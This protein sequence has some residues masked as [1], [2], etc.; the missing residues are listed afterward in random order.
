VDNSLRASPPGDPWG[1]E[2]NEHCDPHVDTSSYGRVTVTLDSPQEKA[3]PKDTMNLIKRFIKEDQGLETVEYAI[4]VG[5]I[6]AGL[7]AIIAAIGAWV[8][9]QFSDLK[10]DLGA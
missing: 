10:T 5:L 4:I 3:F 2:E 1:R 7:V 6:V 9:T 8:K